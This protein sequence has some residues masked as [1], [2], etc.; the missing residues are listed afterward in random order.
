MLKTRPLG[1]IFLCSG[2]ENVSSFETVWNI[3]TKILDPMDDFSMTSAIF[4]KFHGFSRPGKCN[5]KFH[6]F[7]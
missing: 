1:G 6:D 4:P 2:K 7:S 3:W 5:L